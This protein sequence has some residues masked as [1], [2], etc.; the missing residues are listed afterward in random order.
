VRIDADDGLAAFQLFGYKVDGSNPTAPIATSGIKALPDQALDTWPI[1]VSRTDADYTSFSIL[2][3]TNSSVLLTVRVLDID[4]NQVGQANLTLGPHLKALGLNTGSFVFPFGSGDPQINIGDS[5]NVQTV[6]VTGSTNLRVF[7]LTGRG[8]SEIDG[9]AV[10]GL[11]SQA[12]FAR[13]RGV[14]EVFKANG[15]GSVVVTSRENGFD[16]EQIF[17]LNADASVQIP[18]S[19]N[20]DSLSVQGIDFKAVVITRNEVD[21]SISMINGSQVESS[22]KN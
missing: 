18:I 4:G 10:T 21:G 2:N 22:G 9:G 8:N 3:P 1:R 7:E 20:A 16:N 19:D 6:V 17:N 11:T 15:A 5:S 13:P 14:L 12:V